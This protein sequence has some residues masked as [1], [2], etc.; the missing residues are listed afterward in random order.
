MSDKKTD[1]DTQTP[2]TFLDDD[3]SWADPSS[4]PLSIKF[5]PVGV[6]IVGIYIAVSFPAVFGDGPSKLFSDQS[7]HGTFNYTFNITGVKYHAESLATHDW[8]IGTAGEALLELLS[9]KKAVFGSNPF[10]KGKIPSDFFT[11]DDALVWVFEQFRIWHDGPTM[12]YNNYSVSDPASLGVSAVM[13][14]QHWKGW[15]DA[16]GRQ[17]DYLLEQA[18]RYENGAISH[19]V[20]V[21]ELWSDAIYMFPPFLAY[22]GV[23]SKDLDLVKEAVKQIELYREVLRVPDG[24]RKGLWKHIV[25]PSEKA[26]AGAWSTGVGW[27]VYGMARVRA[28]VAAWPKSR[29]AM[30]AEMKALDGYMEEIIDAAIRTDDDPSGLL[31]NYLGDKSWFA[32]TAG[33][34]LI[35]AAAYRLGMFMPPTT[36]RDRILRWADRKRRVVYQHVDLEGVVRPVVHSLRHDQKEPFDGVN[37]EA[38]SFLLVLGAA[39]RDCFCAGV[40]P[41]DA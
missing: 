39:W 27:V 5:L 15:L 14:G 25:G 21:A 17:K 34:S 12:M 29:D 24:H 32:E 8:E 4:W 7:C 40:C 11:M 31:R 35:A 2:K 23:A 10:P 33:T 22:Y 1:Q 41:P 37:P 28:T 18:P 19:R 26:D 6:A 3:W 13:I 38:E 9:P 20:E 36:E 30:Q 16:A